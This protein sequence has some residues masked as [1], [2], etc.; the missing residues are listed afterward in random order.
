LSSPHKVLV[1]IVNY[2]SG[3]SLTQCVTSVF[4]QSVPTEIVV[5]DNDST[6]GSYRTVAERF[7]EVTIRKSSRNLG[8]GAAV[9]LA[10]RENEAESIVVLNP[11]IVLKSESLANLLRTLHDKPGVVGPVLDVIASN[12]REA[13][14]TINHTGMPTLQNAGEPPLFV[15]GCA[16]VTTRTVFEKV[17]GF[18]ERYF[19][20]VEDVEFCWRAL[21]AGFEVSVTSDAEAIHEGGG[22][23]EGGYNPVGT[24]YRTSELRVSLRERNTMALMI[25]CAPW[26]W[27]PAVIPFLIG[28][29]GAIAAGAVAMGRPS[30]AKALL[31]GL[32]WNMKQLPMSVRRRHSLR[33]SRE[34]SRIAR[35]R[36]ISGPL[37]LRTIRAHGIPEI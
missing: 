29:S 36:I 11:D 28:R 1:V 30:L 27:L 15:Q 5:V 33:W 14:L 22:S 26:W 3:S 20:F 37:M 23:I 13:G 6:D 19:L 25:A 7:P 16:L 12:R 24:R 8:F 34:G 9:N 31:T 10:V 17:G 32:G 2:N 35:A 18:D 4:A 21:L